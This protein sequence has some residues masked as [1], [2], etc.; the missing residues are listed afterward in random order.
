MSRFGVVGMSLLVRLPK[1]VCAGLVP[2]W[3]GVLRRLS[4]A[5]NWSSLFFFSKAFAVLTADSA[6]PFDCG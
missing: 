4:N 2:E 3:L 1:K 6:L 5:R